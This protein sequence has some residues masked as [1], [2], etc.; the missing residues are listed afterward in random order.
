MTTQPTQPLDFQD[1]SLACTPLLKHERLV[2]KLVRQEFRLAQGDMAV[3]LLDHPDHLC[4]S[5]AG[6]RLEVLA[7]PVVLDSIPRLHRER[8]LERP[9]KHGIWVVIRSAGITHSYDGIGVVSFK[10][11]DA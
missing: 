6:P 9:A 5:F 8:V 2:L 7:L 10:R 3:V 1:L 11:G 4:A